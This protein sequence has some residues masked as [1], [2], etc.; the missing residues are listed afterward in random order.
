MPEN[1]IS[2]DTG[3][4]SGGSIFSNPVAILRADH[5]EQVGQVFAGLEQARANGLWAAGIASYELGYCLTP[6]L[7]PLLPRNR[8]FPLMLFGLFSGPEHATNTPEP[9]LETTVE[10]IRPVLELD[11]YRTDF[12]RVKEYISAGDVYQVNLTFPMRAYCDANAQRL[13]DALQQRQ[14]VRHGALLQLEEHTVLSRS[15]ELFFKVDSKGEITTRPMKGTAPR[16]KT[17]EEDQ[18]LRVWLASSE[19]N[20]AENLMIVDLL[21]NDIARVAQNGSVTVPSLFAIE[22]YATVHQMTSTVTGQLRENIGLHDLFTA[23]FPCG[24]ITGAPKIRAMQIIAEIERQPREAYCGSIGW[25]S[26]QG[27]MEFNVAIR[28]LQLGQHGKIRLNVGGGV[29]H[30]STAEDEYQEALLKAQYANLKA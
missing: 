14:P 9:S 29:T 20:R 5:P 2:F 11:A 21:R 22:T 17:P 15:P 13:Y 6:K 3:P 28:T 24:S 23:L 26:P 8:G 19:K 18:E 4:L 10:Q 30:D 25:I 16:G 1:A 27:P 12:K 7:C